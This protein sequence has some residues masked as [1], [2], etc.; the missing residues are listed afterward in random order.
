MVSGRQL[1]EFERP[2]VA[3]VAL[4]VVFRELT[5][6]SAAH[7]GLIWDRFRDLYPRAEAHPPLDLAPEI[8]PSEDQT[9]K[10]PRV[11]MLSRPKLR[12]WFINEDGT[13]L[14]Q[15]QS[16]AFIHNWRKQPRDTQYPRY[17]TVRKSF[18]Q[19][20]EQFAD[21]VATSDLG[22]IE[23]TL[24]EL[25][26]VNH[27]QVPD[28]PTHQSLGDVMALWTE[29]RTDFLP[30]IEDAQLGARYP[31]YSPD[32]EFL[33]RLNVSAKPAYLS[34]TQEEI[35]NLTLIAR[36]R[37]TSPSIEGA[38]DFLDLGHEWIVNGFADVTTQRMQEIW[39]RKL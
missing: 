14:L 12:C 22:A 5:G 27:I 1:P 20:F 39:G 11:Q 19:E 24:C 33:G 30:A 21:F 7:F 25:S 16:T 32:G 17:E 6:F 4:A 28:K 29:P 26:Y 37:P 9:Q 15:V 18:V 31:I 3:E 36:G 2:P 23:P 35:L 38:L 34:G 13:Q 10:P 8:P